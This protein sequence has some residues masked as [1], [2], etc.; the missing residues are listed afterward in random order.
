MDALRNPKA[1]PGCPAGLFLFDTRRLT[2]Q[3]KGLNRTT[4]WANIRIELAM[5]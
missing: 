2:G 5:S 3:L 1:L 4:G